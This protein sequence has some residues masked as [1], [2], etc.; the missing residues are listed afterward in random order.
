[1]LYGLTSLFRLTHLLNRL[2]NPSTF[3]GWFGR[4]LFHV[5]TIWFTFLMSSSRVLRIAHLFF[6]SIE[7]SVLEDF[8]YSC[9][10]R[11][12]SGSNSLW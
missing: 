5:S 11:L 9:L 10:C 3:A 12:L 6:S 1:M 4:S 7:F 8:A 2:L